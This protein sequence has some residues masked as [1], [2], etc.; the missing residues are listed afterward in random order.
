MDYKGGKSMSKIKSLLVGAA[1]IVATAT[2]ASAVPIVLPTGPGDI[3]AIKFTN[4][5]NVINGAN[6]N[7]FAIDAGDTIFGILKVSS[8][9]TTISSNQTYSNASSP[10]ELTGVF[11]IS[12]VAGSIAFGSPVGHVD[13]ALNSGDYFNFYYDDA[14][15]FNAQAANSVANASDGNLWL[16]ITGSDYVQGYADAAPGLT[17]YNKNWA[18]PTVNN[19][20]YN[21]TSLLWPAVIGQVGV[22]PLPTD[23]Y[24]ESKVND[25][26]AGTYVDGW[27]YLSQDP[28]YAQAS[29]VP[30]PGTLLLL[31]AGL[32]GLAIVAKRRSKK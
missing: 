19:T 26:L 7:P 2:S 32:T 28:F 20:G 4:Y 12:V 31:G 14:K 25:L 1:L 27:K 3:T 13:F 5:E 18:N 29:A 21:F 11:Q 8:I 22:A 23:F 9:D 24:F 16:S 17:T 30:E 6:S 15:N 10:Y